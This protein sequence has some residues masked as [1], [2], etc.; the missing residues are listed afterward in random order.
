MKS[1][2]S[3]KKIYHVM[4]F[5]MID[6]CLTLYILLT[7]S[8]FLTYQWFVNLNSFTILYYYDTMSVLW[9]IILISTILTK[10]LYRPLLSSIWFQPLRDKINDSE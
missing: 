6:C 5:I 3:F 10:I 2:K 4:L 9:F 1:K 7:V 8:A